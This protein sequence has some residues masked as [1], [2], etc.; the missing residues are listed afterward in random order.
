MKLGGWA[1]GG[2]LEVKAAGIL[3]FFCSFLH[4][5]G[6]SSQRNPSWHQ[7]WDTGTQNVSRAA[8][9][10]GPGARGATA[11][12]GFWGSGALA[13]AVA[14]VSE[15]QVCADFLWNW[16]L[17]SRDHHSDLGPR[18]RKRCSNSRISG[19]TGFNGSLGHRGRM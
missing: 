16:A 19:M 9:A 11:A 18:G 2:S 13:V 1:V 14:L 12:P 15:V 8:C 7:V 4:A 3:G 5:E 10:L 6:S 17:V